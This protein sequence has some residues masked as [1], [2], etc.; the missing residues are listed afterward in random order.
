MHLGQGS[1]GNCK[2]L[3][4]IRCLGR[5]NRMNTQT[6][7][8]ILQLLHRLRFRLVVVRHLAAREFTEHALLI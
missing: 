8:D 2:F 1:T 3:P 5:L 4:G 7:R 6:I